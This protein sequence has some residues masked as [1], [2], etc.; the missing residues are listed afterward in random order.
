M[1]AEKEMS[2]EEDAAKRDALKQLLDAGD[3]EDAADAPA[4]AEGAE[5]AQEGAMEE[6]EGKVEEAEA[7]EGVDLAPLMETL[8][9]TEERAQK[10][11]D[12]AQQ[13]PNLAGKTPQELSDMIASDFDVLMQLEM[14]AARGDGGAMG[15]PPAGGMPPAGPEG[16]P[17]GQ[18]MPPEG[19]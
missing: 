9:A 13:I 18:M 4:A 3:A 8:G 16:M 1:A 5:M 7:T 19:M 14:A 6:Q 2:P 12:A 11:Y 15:G 17:P 10:L